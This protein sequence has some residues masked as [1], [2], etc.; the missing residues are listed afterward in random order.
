MV[1]HINLCISQTHAT[2]FFA[3]CLIMCASCIMKLLCFIEVC[4]GIGVMF[5]QITSLSSTLLL[6][7]M[8]E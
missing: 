5:D 6:D 7:Q 4:C 1:C 3:C 2:S 8:V